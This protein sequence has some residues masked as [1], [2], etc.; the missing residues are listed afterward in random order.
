MHVGARVPNAQD[1]VLC[2]KQDATDGKRADHARIEIQKVG[3]EGSDR[4]CFAANRSRVYATL[5]QLI[6]DTAQESNGYFGFPMFLPPVP[7]QKQRR[8]T[9]ASAFGGMFKSGKKDKDKDKPTKADKK[10]QKK[11]DKVAKGA[12][13]VPEQAFPDL[14]DEGG[15]DTNALDGDVGVPITQRSIYEDAYV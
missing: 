12:A 5:E 13:M 15:G 6:G 9:I 2:V 14:P 3:G 8:R 11:A 4:V 10:A 1:Y 7:A